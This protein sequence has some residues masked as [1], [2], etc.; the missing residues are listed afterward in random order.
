MRP[1]S[2]LDPATYMKRYGAS[3]AS[4]R[5]EIISIPTELRTGSNA[6]FW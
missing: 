5:G 2:L 3:D 4:D 6:V 1:V